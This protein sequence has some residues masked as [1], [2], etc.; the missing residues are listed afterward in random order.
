MQRSKQYLASRRLAVTGMLA[1]IIILLTVTNIGILQINPVVGITFLCLPIF[2]GLM[3]EGL[4]VGLALGATF[5]VSSFVSA[6]SSPTLLAPYF[7]NPL[8]SVLPRLLIPVT[9]WLV[10]RALEPFAKGGTIKRSLARAIAALIGSLTNTA[11]VLGMVLIL[12]KLGIVADGLDATGIVAFLMGIV[13]SNG[14]PEAIAMTI[15]TP[16][17][18]AALDRAIYK[19]KGAA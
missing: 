8:V 6:F 18:V 15:V 7:M 9:A 1:G 14:I 2:V 5:G 17:V 10:L 12:C 13:V 19:T 11:G 3:T 4:G 16:P